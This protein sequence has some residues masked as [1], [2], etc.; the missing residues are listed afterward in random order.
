MTS[1]ILK[2]IYLQKKSFL[3]ALGYSLFV[4]IVF[5]NEIFSE[6][7]YIM[8]A[9]ATAYMLVLGACAYE[10]KNNSE[11]ILNSL[12]LKRADIVRA[13]YLSSFVSVF[14]AFV[15]IGVLGALMKGVGLPIPLRYVRISDVIAVIVSLSLLCS[16]YFPVYFRYGYIKSRF[17]N[18]ILFLLVFFAPSTGL[19]YLR[20]DGKK[21]VLNQVIDKLAGVPDWQ[22]SVGLGIAA[23]I[24]T[25]ISM[26][27]SVCIYLKRE[28]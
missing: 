18:L 28:F 6:T 10:E 12:P 4:L 8:G 11:V 23:W 20:E 24:L 15:I 9:M 16:L 21:E 19:S 26:R 2:D 27:I 5:Q 25:A 1:L 14:L 22:I 17:F 7:S 13:R 3:F